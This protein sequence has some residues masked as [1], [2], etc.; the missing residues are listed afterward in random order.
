[1][2]EKRKMLIKGQN[3]VTIEI[4][5]YIIG[6][7]LGGFLDVSTLLG[8]LIFGSV[9]S[10]LLFHGNKVI[11]AIRSIVCIVNF[12]Q[13]LALLFKTIGTEIMD[14]SA[15]ILMIILLILIL[16]LNIFSFLV[17]IVF[18]SSTLFF[19][20]QR[21]NKLESKMQRIEEEYNSYE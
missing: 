6:I 7:L 11:R 3:L 21:K 8:K 2:D 20:E 17:L 19:N 1:M 18:P 12:F 10:Y 16:A 13:V 15:L 5:F 9:F 4:I 14:V